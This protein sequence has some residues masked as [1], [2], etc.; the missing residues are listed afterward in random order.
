MDINMCT[1]VGYSSKTD[2]NWA[3]K[4]ISNIGKRMRSYKCPKC[5]KYHLTSDVNGT[6]F[7]L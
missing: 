7:R 4:R 5:F 2:A 6:K 1:K 3:L